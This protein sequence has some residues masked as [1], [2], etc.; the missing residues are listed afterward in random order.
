MV[1][2]SM[3]KAKSKSAKISKDEKPSF[4]ITKHVLVP[5][6]RILSKKEVEDLLKIY[7]ISL[8]QLPLIKEKDPVI[9]AISAKAGDVI[10]IIRDGPT[11][12]YPFYRMVIE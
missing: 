10:E 11:R 12:N 6:H 7:D 1:G 9:N 4:N 5:N 8:H 3:V 2:A